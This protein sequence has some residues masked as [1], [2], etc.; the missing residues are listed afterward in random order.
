MT[1]HVTISTL[2]YARTGK[3]LKSCSNGDPDFLDELK[4]C[5]WMES[6][7]HMVILASSK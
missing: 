7:E 2:K 4:G 6:W 1:I 3:N 5:G